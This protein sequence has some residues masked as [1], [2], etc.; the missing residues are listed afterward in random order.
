MWTIAT[1]RFT[2]YASER[3]C[4]FTTAAK[5][6]GM[7][8]KSIEDVSP[9]TVLQNRHYSVEPDAGRKSHR[10]VHLW[11]TRVLVRR[12]LH[13][14]LLRAVTAMPILR[15]LIFQEKKRRLYNATLR[16]VEKVVLLLDCSPGEIQMTC[17]TKLF[18]FVVQADDSTS[19]FTWH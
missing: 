4:A 2:E 7:D 19:R 3:D 12:S 15:N 8:V 14:R 13:R 10:Y 18:L 16:F 17:A 9:C 5:Q 11:A 1:T 6:C